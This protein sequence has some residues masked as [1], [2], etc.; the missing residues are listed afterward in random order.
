MQTKNETESLLKT[1]IMLLF[2][3]SVQFNNNSML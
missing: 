2:T 1:P 3:D